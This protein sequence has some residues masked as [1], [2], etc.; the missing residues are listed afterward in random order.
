MTTVTCLPCHASL[1]K[2][3]A[4]VGNSQN[5][6]RSATVNAG[7]GNDTSLAV[8][9]RRVGFI[10]MLDLQGCQ[11]RADPLQEIASELQHGTLIEH[12]HAKTIASR[13]CPD[14]NNA[15]ITRDTHSRRATLSRQFAGNG[16]R[17]RRCWS[18][19]SCFGEPTLW[20]DRGFFP[21]VARRSW[22]TLAFDRPSRGLFSSPGSSSSAASPPSQPP[23]FCT[24]TRHARD[25]C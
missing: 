7:G 16:A 21:S 11:F 9:N 24:S 22:R 14:T 2:L 19:W 17:R 10:Y 5:G 18:C 12:G 3:R 8:S 15:R 25:T 20:V 6:S 23:A 4:P 13:T 1:P